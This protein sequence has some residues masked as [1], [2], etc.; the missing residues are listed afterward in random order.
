MKKFTMFIQEHMSFMLFQLFLVLFIMFLY[1]LDG[2]RNF[3]TA[4]T[5]SV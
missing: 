2:F 4:C 5:P 3:N 1:W